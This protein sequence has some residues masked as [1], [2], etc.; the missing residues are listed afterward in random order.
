MGFF[1]RQD[2]DGDSNGRSTGNDIESDSQSESLSRIEA[3][4]IPL[5]VELR[6]QGIGADG[7]FFT[8]GLLVNEYALL[9]KVGPRPLA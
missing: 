7:S 8:S 1:R 3:G 9:G 2:D 6:L 4:G 5:A